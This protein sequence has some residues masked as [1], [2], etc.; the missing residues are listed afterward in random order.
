[1][2]RYT[3]RRRRLHPYNTESIGSKHAEREEVVAPC[4]AARIELP[5]NRI[6]VQGCL[7]GRIGEFENLLKEL[8]MCQDNGMFKEHDQLV[9]EKI[10]YYEGRK[11]FTMVWVLKIEKSAT[12]SYQ[13]KWK[14]AR[15]QLVSVIYSDLM[16]EYS[17]LIKAR[18][19]Y[20][21]VAHMR[22]KKK[23][24]KSK[25]GLSCLLN[26]LDESKQLLHGYNSP[27]DWAELY[28]TYGCVRMDYASQLPLDKRKVEE[29]KAMDCFRRAIYFSKQDDRERVQ[30][31]RQSYVHLKL[32]MKHLGC[33]SAFPLAQENHLPLNDIKEAE[34]HLDIVQSNFGDT[35]PTATTMLLLKAQSYLFYCQGK[36]Q[37]A[38]DKA[39]DAHECALRH[40]FNTELNILKERKDF[41]QKELETHN[42]ILSGKLKCP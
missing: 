22:R 1:M 35:I 19:L 30:M 37:L 4:L 8:E 18:A 5:I 20:L 25:T 16:V 17:N 29:E 31:K 39:V 24:R 28:Q 34:K 3:R 33:C 10:R 23:Y 12:Y 14:Q 2:R 9:T 21:L 11:N 26:Y 36:H 15:K 7:S 13:N 27:E 42:Q 40:G 41:H 6:E 38:R 32:A